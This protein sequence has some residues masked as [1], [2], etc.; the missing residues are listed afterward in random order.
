MKVD[1]DEVARTEK[2]LYVEMRPGVGH[3]LDWTRLGEVCGHRSHWTASHIQPVK[4]SCVFN[5]YSYALNVI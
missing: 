5:M 1:G 3:M 4:Y 2:E